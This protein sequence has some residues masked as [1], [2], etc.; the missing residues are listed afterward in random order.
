MIK[1]LSLGALIF[2]LINL[3]LSTAFAEENLT[4]IIL[5]TQTDLSDWDFESYKG[6]KGWYGN[7][8]IVAEKAKT[9]I[10]QKINDKGVRFSEV[11]GESYIRYDLKENDRFTWGIDVKF[12]VLPETGWFQTIGK[13]SSGGN[14]HLINVSVKDGVMSFYNGA[15]VANTFT[16]DTKSVYRMEYFVDKV[17]NQYTFRINGI[18]VAENY[19]FQNKSVVD[20]YQLRCG[21]GNSDANPGDFSIDNMWV[22]SYKDISDISSK[23]TESATIK[24]NSF[25]SMP[26]RESYIKFNKLSLGNESIFSFK[27]KGTEKTN[28]K[29]ALNDGTGKIV[30]FEINNSENPDIKND[31]WNDII[32]ILNRESKILTLYLNDSMKTQAVDLSDFDFSECSFEVSGT[33]VFLDDFSIVRDTAKI[34]NLKLL[35]ENLYVE[36]KTVSVERIYAG[37]NKLNMTF[38]DNRDKKDSTAIF[39]HRQKGNIISVNLVPVSYEG[40]IGTLSWQKNIKYARDD[41]LEVYIWDSLKGIIPL[42]EKR[43]YNNRPQNKPYESEIEEAFLKNKA[44]HPYII[45]DASDFE[46]ARSY[47]NS[48]S[49]DEETLRIK[50]WIDKIITDADAIVDADIHDVDSKYYVG[51]LDVNEWVLTVGRRILNFTEQLGFAYQITNDKKYTEKI[52]E[53]LE[54]AGYSENPV[55]EDCFSDWNP[56]HYLGTAMMTTAFAVGYDWGYNGFSDS[57]KENIENSIYH[58]GLSEGIRGYSENAPWASYKNNWAV[59]CN[60]GMLIGALAVMNKYPEECYSIV[61]DARDHLEIVIDLFNAD[62]LW[63]ESIG[64]GQGVLQYFIKDIES[65]RNCLGNDYGLWSGQGLN[66]SAESYIYLDGPTGNFNFHDVQKNYGHSNLSEIFWI[67]NE[68]A[69]KQLSAIRLKNME[70]YNLSPTVY[71][72]LWYNNSGAEIT[73][74]KDKYFDVMQMF[75]LRGDLFD[76]NAMWVAAEGGKNNIDHCHLDCGNFVLDWG[77]YR[78]ALDLGYDDYTLP[79]YFSNERY[80]YYRVRA[81]GHNTLVINPSSERD[82]KVSASAPVE[83]FVSDEEYAFA[84]INLT[85]AYE[86]ESVR[87]G[88]YLG[89]NRK[90]LTIRDELRLNSASDEVYWF[91]HTDATVNIIKNKAFLQKGMKKMQVEFLAENCDAVIDCVDAKSMTEIPGT[92]NED[93]NTGVKKLRIKLTN[94]ENPNLTVKITPYGEGES[95]S[96]ISDKSL[97]EWE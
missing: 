91:M 35:I 68:F 57:Q 95:Y 45:A 24:D 59:T 17:L 66:K 16:L 63:Q 64:Y 22:K 5:K 60:S 36:D 31:K 50:K 14:V 40:N 25:V 78:W 15:T 34:K 86:A 73:L 55:Y 32:F 97:D 52:Y 84:V 49:T 30:F 42:T 96:R 33:N 26:D 28:G 85:S 43:L 79:G 20:F 11:L 27:L 48:S 72:V 1:K 93:S 62:G 81:E 80:N 87:R 51:Y 53:I 10:S 56:E 54:K 4:D 94:G 2:I 82:Q 90:S 7:L 92:E 41:T 69:D 21:F 38:Y 18:T 29:F 37:E 76:K 65:L 44:V 70:L 19:N 6:N 12:E 83:R 23:G 67:A 89:D 9:G 3:L 61:S 75:T 47:Y 74:R 13:N 71:D 77:G 39:V 88:F 46:R 8:Q 58:F